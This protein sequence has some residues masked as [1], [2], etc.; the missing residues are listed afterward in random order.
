MN[1]VAI[2]T[3]G[4]PRIIM[5]SIVLPLGTTEAEIAGVAK[6]DRAQ[7]CRVLPPNW[8]H[9]GYASAGL[10]LPQKRKDSRQAH[11]DDKEN[12]HY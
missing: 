9:Q 7:R 12:I 3:S 4:T 8:K 2:V 5:V 1:M 10:Y 6:H 11:S